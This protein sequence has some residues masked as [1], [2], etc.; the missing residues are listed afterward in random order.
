MRDIYKESETET[1]RETGDIGH[2]FFI[3]IL[4][5]VRAGSK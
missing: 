3:I 5:S 2:F 4:L 1:E